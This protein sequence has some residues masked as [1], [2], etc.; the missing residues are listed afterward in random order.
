MRTM[1]RRAALLF[2][3]AISLCS[4]PAGASFH[5]WRI[6]EIFS[7]DDGTVQFIEFFTTSPGQQFLSGHNLTATSDG[8]MPVSYT[9]PGAL[10]VPPGE[11]TANRHFLL[12]TSAFASLPGAVVPNFTPL[13]NKF[14]D[15]D[16]A[17]IVFSFAHG[18]D[19]AT[20]AGS[21]IPVDGVNSITDS[22]LGIPFDTADTYA[23]GTNSP[24]NFAGAF[25]QVNAAP[26]PAAD[27]TGNGVVNEFDL[28]VW[29]VGF[30]TSTGAAKSQGDSD[31]DM[32]V[33]G[34]DFLKWQEQ[35]TSMGAAGVVPEQATA[36]L[37]GAAACAL[38]TRFRRR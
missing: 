8:G 35:T 34:H 21:L 18:A 20:V 24:T 29:R 12:A 22:V 1:P 7:N 4:A 31:G 19:S 3:A 38:A 16:A 9:F 23:V 26:S 14:F 25:G 5:D 37:V 15:P 11:S 36:D 13:P 2:F 6:K 17:S 27:F 10:P 32:D 28:A 30:G 33:D